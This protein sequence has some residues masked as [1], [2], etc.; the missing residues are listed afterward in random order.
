MV[1]KLATANS[2]EAIAKLTEV[3]VKQLF[4]IIENLKSI[5]PAAFTDDKDLTKQ[6]AHMDQMVD[7]LE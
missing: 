1:I 4:L 3:D 7:K 2:P 5:Y 6:L